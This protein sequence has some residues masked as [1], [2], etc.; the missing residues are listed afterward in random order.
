LL[1]QAIA[2]SP[3][4]LPGFERPV[5]RTRR[6]RLLALGVAGSLVGAGAGLLLPFGDSLVGSKD[7][8]SG[9]AALTVSPPPS[10]ANGPVA[11]APRHTATPSRSPRHSSQGG[12]DFSGTGAKKLGTIRVDDPVFMRWST[13]SG[14]F[15]VVSEAW[16]FRPRTREGRLLL[17]PGTYRRFEIRG[18]GRWR[19][20]LDKP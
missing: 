13:Q 20:E 17:S 8:G 9:N 16:G 14:S 11:A 4:E 12:T 19:L 1:E 15:R 7:K 5:E 18:T 6:L 10:G 3:A 2:P